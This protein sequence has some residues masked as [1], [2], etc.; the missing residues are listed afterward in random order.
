MFY[1][2]LAADYDML[3]D[4][5]WTGAQWHGEIVDAMLQ[6]HGVRPPARVLDCA[7]GI[8]TQSIPLVQRGYDVTATDLSDEAI[9]RARREARE[10]G[11]DL[12]AHVA[13]MRNV[14]AVV[15]G[16]FDAVIACD[17]AVPHL[18]DDA[19]LDAALGAIKRV[20]APNGVFLASVR[21][22]DAIKAAHPPGIPAVF[23]RRAYGRQI[24]GQ[25]WEWSD[26]DECIRIHLFRIEER[27]PDDWQPTVY[28]TWYRVLTR[29]KFIAAL[30]R[31]GF[32]DI[33]WYT[34]DECGYHQP[35]VTARHAP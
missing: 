1:D 27:A 32:D 20:L 22:Y 30:Q 8:G 2:A 4:D 12:D 24:A 13:D 31:R 28:T 16:P 6:R 26:D 17:N 23:R 19:D 25:A 11:L 3:F 9:A 35:M 15:T 33:T 34:A 10:R 29:A 14:D 18:L 21:D 7:A 5:W